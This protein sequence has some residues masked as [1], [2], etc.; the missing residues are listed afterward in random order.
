MVLLFPE[1]ER[2]DRGVR[3]L[4]RVTAS[5]LDKLTLRCQYARGEL[6]QTAG[7]SQARERDFKVISI[8]MF[9]FVLKKEVG[10]VK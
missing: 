8:Q 5:V 10:L 4:L 9:C 3:E 2:L 1:M 7:R 6:K